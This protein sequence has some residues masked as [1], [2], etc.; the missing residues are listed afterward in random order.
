M[1]HTLY[2]ASDWS[3][4][5]QNTKIEQGRQQPNQDTN[6]AELQRIKAVK[7]RLGSYPLDPYD[8]VLLDK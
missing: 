5:S 7:S 4:N 1:A 6:Q 3:S 8:S 2:A